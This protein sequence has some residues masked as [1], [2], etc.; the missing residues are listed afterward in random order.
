MHPD[1]RR[2]E[3]ETTTEFLDLVAA[4]DLLLNP[5][6][7]QD[8]DL[9]LGAQPRLRRSGEVL[10]HKAVVECLSS[11]ARLG[12]KARP[13]GNGECGDDNANA[14]QDS[15]YRPGLYN[16]DLAARQGA[17]ARHLAENMKADV[18]LQRNLGVCFLVG[19]AL[20]NA[21]H[22]CFRLRFGLGAKRRPSDG[23]PGC[24]YSGC[25]F[26]EQYYVK[27]TRAQIASGSICCNI[28]AESKEQRADSRVGYKG[29]EAG[30]REN[31]NRECVNLLLV[32]VMVGL[33]HGY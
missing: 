30:S 23:C 8:W 26:L 25:V 2:G 18:V 12:S 5:M 6:K 31:A 17:G 10:G 32:D 21:F 33:G 15:L 11:R 7:R 19:Q 1:R 4:K 28:E 24:D 16:V 13:L 3:P 27:A 14:Q 9:T 29:I 20:D 22:F